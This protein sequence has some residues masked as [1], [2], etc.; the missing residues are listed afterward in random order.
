MRELAEGVLPALVGEVAVATPLP[1]YAMLRPRAE[2]ST[3]FQ[4]TTPNV[5]GS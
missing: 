4:R 3:I 5:A 2:I 1:V